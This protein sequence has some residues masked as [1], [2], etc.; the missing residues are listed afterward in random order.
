MKKLTR[1][2]WP[3]I[4]GWTL[5]RI[6]LFVLSFLADK[7]LVYAPT[8]PYYETFLP[9]FGWPRWIYSWANFDGVHYL[10]IMDHGYLG[11]GLLQAFFPV[12]PL[13]SVAVHSLT[14]L[15]FFTS[16]LLVAHLSSLILC[17][18]IWHWLVEQFDHRSA[19]FGLLWWL[20]FP[21]AFFTV[22]LYGESL[23]LVFALG[24]WLAAKK[25]KW[26]LAGGLAALASGTRVVGIWLL[27]MLLL[28]LLQ[29]TNW[30]WHL[31]GKWLAQ[32]WSKVVAV[33]LSVTGLAA[34]MLYLW[35][36]FHDPLYFLHL[37]S[38][39][40]A[41]RQSSLVWW[42][43]VVWRAVKILLTARP[44][45]WKYFA[46]VQE[47]IMGVG[48]VVLVLIGW[49]KR[50]TTGLTTPLAIYSLGCLIMPTF[51]GTFS[52]LP[53]Y[54]LAA[55]P[56]WLTLVAWSRSSRWAWLGMLFS[57]A[58]LIINTILFIQGYWVA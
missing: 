57:L 44:F 52:S 9:S 13:L 53:R 5:W 39:F 27:P 33:G 3:V 11:W 36:Q 41:G 35:F 23:F 22:A 6:G 31:T 19:K 4:A 17:L 29:Q 56:M 18:L 54:L 25:G 58:M 20:V 43:Q 30:R 16:G 50:K 38:E 49:W 47:F 15:N 8:F 24:A 12:F 40:G 14:H 7:F 51:T 46:Y 21:T 10:L 2:I 32:H 48:S 42:P 34:Y 55:W 45:D 37:Q 26:W 28:E 1:I